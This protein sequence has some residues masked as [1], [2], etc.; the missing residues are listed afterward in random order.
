MTQLPVFLGSL[1]LSIVCTWCVRRIAN[2]RGWVQEPKSDRH[3]HTMPVPRLGGVAIY[4]SFMTMVIVATVI[5]RLM[6]SASPLVDGKAMMGLLGPGLL[7]FLLG[8]WDD[9]QSLNA[10]WKFSVQTAAA[11]WLYA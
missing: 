3:M 8:L 9:V 11:I 7:I 5:P 1:L 10:Y 4:F 6:G 2:A